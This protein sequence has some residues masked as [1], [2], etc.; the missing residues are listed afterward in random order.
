MD[1]CTKCASNVWEALHWH[2]KL[3]G[4]VTKALLRE[5]NAAMAGLAAELDSV[6]PGGKSTLAK[7]LFL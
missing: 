3:L 6:H 7:K 2:A 5:T 4:A 1:S